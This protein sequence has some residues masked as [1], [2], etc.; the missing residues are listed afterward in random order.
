MEGDV[1]YVLL[2]MVSSFCFYV[3]YVTTGHV[4]KAYEAL[5]TPVKPSG[6]LIAT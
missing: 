5:K 2:E 1:G 3:N 6:F 4:S